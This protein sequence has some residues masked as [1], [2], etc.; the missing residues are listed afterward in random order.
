[1]TSRGIIKD[2]KQPNTNSSYKKLA[3]LWLNEPLCFALSSVVTDSLILRNRQLL[4]AAK[5]LTVIILLLSSAI[6]SGAQ[7]TDSLHSLLR[8]AQAD[9]DRVMLMCEISEAFHRENSDSAM[10]YARSADSLASSIH[11]ALGVAWA[12]RLMAQ[13]YDL[14]LNYAEGLKCKLAALEIYEKENYTKG[15][16]LSYSNIGISYYYL[17]EYDQAIYYYNKKIEIVKTMQDINYESVTRKLMLSI[18]LCY[19]EKKEYNKALEYMNLSLQYEKNTGNDSAHFVLVYFNL[20]VI[21]TTLNQNQQALNSYDTALAFAAG[22]YTKYI[23]AIQIGIGE[24]YSHEGKY[25]PAIQFLESGLKL[26]SESGDIEREQV[27]YEVLVEVYEANGDYKN[28]LRY[29]KKLF[30]AHDSIH[31][32]DANARIAALRNGFEMKEKE[33]ELS[34]VESER[35]LLKANSERDELRFIAFGIAGLLIVLVFAFGI[36]LTFVKNKHQRKVQEMELAKTR[37]ELEQKVLRAQLNPHFIFNSLNSIQD[38]ILRSE[39]GI[40][41]DY[42]ARFSKLIRLVLVNSEKDVISLNKEIEFLNIYME[43]E[44]RRFKDK[45]DYQI[46]YDENLPTDEIF[47]PVMLVQ[48]FVENAIWHGIMNLEGPVRGNVI[49]RF[50]LEHDLLTISILD[51]G[52]GRKATEEQRLQQGHK[53][54][55]ML[56]SQKRLETI[57][58]TGK[59]LSHILVTD[60]Y[61]EGGDATGT[62]VDIELAL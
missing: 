3:A 21:Y 15:I 18:G 7:S 9:T 41:Y 52:V 32:A 37:I 54:M 34:I 17:D 44:Q 47:I 51:N 60:L 49:I 53:S 28:A 43:L 58:A 23:G 56:F 45:F 26:V 11:Y 39:T 48:P 6:R 5:R 50:L 30:A 40:A 4:V 38:Y 14:Q 59:K 16:A 36:V 20:G 29:Q 1:M 55:G 8:A 22:S 19:L 13:E 46:N 12:Y 10:Y 62:R 33:K 31:N 42:L 27:A 24:V 35:N 57:K 25:G 61:N 2:I